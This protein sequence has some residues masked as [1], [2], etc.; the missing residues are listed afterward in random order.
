MSVTCSGYVWN[1]ALGATDRLYYRPGIYDTLALYDAQTKIPP[2]RYR[3][4]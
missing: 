3:D 4:D 2:W 1:F